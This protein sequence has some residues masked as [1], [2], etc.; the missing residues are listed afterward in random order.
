MTYKPL[1]SGSRVLI[2]AMLAMAL[3]IIADALFTRVRLDLTEN[4]LFTLSE[5]TINII[6]SLEEPISL[7]F[8]LS[9]K[10]LAGFPQLVNYANRVRDLLEEYAARSGGKIELTIIEPEPFSEAEDE[11]V[12]SGLQGV[13]VNASGDLAYF[14]LV[15]V[16]STDDEANIPFFQASQEAALEYDVTKLIFNLANPE[17]RVVGVISGLPLFVDVDR[18][19]R[20]Q[21]TIINAIGEFFAVRDLGTDVTQIDKDISVLMIVHPKGL[22]E[23]SLFAI[24]QYL[25]GGGNA[26]LFVDPLAE[27]DNAGPD[28]ANPYVIP[29]MGSDLKTILDGWGVEVAT[30]HI[31][32]DINLAMRVQTQGGRGPQ[33]SHYLPWLALNE[34]NLNRDDFSTRELKLIHMGTVGVI[35]RKEGASIALTPLIQTTTES[36]KMMRDLVFFQRDPDV[37]LAN[38]ASEGAQLTLAARISGKVPGAYPDGLPDD[39]GETDSAEQTGDDGNVIKE[40]DINVILV[41]DTDILSDHFWVR[42]Q[43]FFGVQIPQTIANNGDFVIN[44][45]DNLSGNTD[46]IS[47]RSRGEFSRPFKVVEQIRRDAE[48][49]FRER[50]QE[51]R[52]K[53]EETERKIVQL[54]QEGGQSELLLSP[55]QAREIE[56]FQLEQIKT[57]KELRAVQHELQKNIEH[58]GTQLKFINIGLIP[59]IIIILATLA[60]IQ[61]SRRKH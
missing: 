48:A 5:G 26:M 15:G 46:L 31:A 57:R 58:L 6:R 61:R 35:E 30:D 18:G 60:G 49:Q 29:D 34:A 24:D 45:L 9:S 32:A 54:Q 7:E 3:I 28:P 43:N 11:A 59:L 16:N 14:G 44:S 10:V 19:T 36:M 2:A 39:A 21:W 40:G 55:E 8:Y 33:E 4:K 37:M 52:A 1:R 50:E 42:T 17:K 38:F 56:K 12:A 53:L 20:E 27:A 22:N 51:L 13:S 41:A 25:L 23:E 47:L